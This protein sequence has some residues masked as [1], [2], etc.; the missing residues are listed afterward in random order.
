M[1]NL[2]ALIFLNKDL[3]VSN[4]LSFRRSLL[5]GPVL[6]VVTPVYRAERIVDELVLR[7]HEILRSLAPDYEVILVDD[8][9]PDGSWA[10]IVNNCSKHRFVKGIRLSRNFG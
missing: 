9:S 5:K 3:V 8:G 7:L 1:P 4:R 10:K 2:M 6:S